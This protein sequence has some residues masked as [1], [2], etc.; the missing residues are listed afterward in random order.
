MVQRHSGYTLVEIAIVVVIISLLMVAVFKGQ[1]LVDQSHTSEAI[2]TMKDLKVAVDAF[3]QKF[4]YL[5]GDFPLDT[6]TPEITGFTS[7]S[8]CIT[9]DAAHANG[10]GNGVIS[11]LE[12]PCATEQLIR[13][14]LIKGDPTLPIPTR[15]GYVWLASRDNSGALTAYSAPVQ[16]VIV[17]SNIPCNMALE[18][19]R[20]LDDG[21]LTA[22]NIR[23]SKDN[24]FCLLSDNEKVTLATFSMAL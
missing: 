17:L 15:Q 21:T 6:T 18:I 10:N 7:S 9:G 8:K 13:A 22:G 3:K 11:A 14:E 1:S 24:A 16:N 20:K 12:S 19:D 4:H 5:P 23:A 2:T